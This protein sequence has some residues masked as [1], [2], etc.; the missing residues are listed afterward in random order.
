VAGDVDYDSGGAGYSLVRRTDPRIA[1]HVHAALRNA[2]SVINVGAGTGSYEPTDRVV[3]AVEPSAAMRAQRPPHLSAAVDAVAEQLPFRDDAFDAAMAMVTIHQ[4]R[5]LDRGLRELRRVSRGPVVILLAD[6]DALADFWLMDYVPEVIRAEQAR[7][8]DVAHVRQVLGGTSTVTT[9]PIPLDCVDG[10]SEAFYGRPE[11]LLDESV[12]SAQSSW[13]FV[14]PDVAE[15]GL[16]RLRADL[17]SGD[18]DRRYGHLR[19]QPEYLGS[20]RLL[21]AHP[22]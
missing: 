10:F 8:R 20:L 11:R 15:R 13:G 1:G 14:T 2:R 4:W 17:E 12:R 18:W 21:V 16:D 7:N 19:R 22:G 6:C 3:T 5:D 9:V